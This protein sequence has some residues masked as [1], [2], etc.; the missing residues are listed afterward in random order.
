MS[1]PRHTVEVESNSPGPKMDNLDD[2][3][4]K[5][6][7]VEIE[8]EIGE[9][10]VVAEEEVLDEVVEGPE[11]EQL[12]E[13]AVL[14]GALGE[15]GRIDDGLG[16]PDSSS[17]AN[18]VQSRESPENRRKARLKQMMQ[19]LRER[20]DSMADDE[21]MEL[22]ESGLTHVVEQLKEP[23]RSAQVGDNF[24]AEEEEKTVTCYIILIAPRITLDTAED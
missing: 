18:D 7:K 8:E 20:V 4:H 1:P 22:M 9:Y 13:E 19:I 21:T 14:N 17:S 23:P 24:C 10:V 2:F 16:L 12:V 5:R 11:A 6:M 3:N 15:V